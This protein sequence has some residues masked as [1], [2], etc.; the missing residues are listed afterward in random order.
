MPSNQNRPPSK[1]S[2]TNCWSHARAL[3]A[4]AS[5]VPCKAIFLAWI[6][7][8]LSSGPIQSVHPTAYK[9]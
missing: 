7:Q 2:L 3:G 5:D 6:P 9:A 4:R 8:S 1:L